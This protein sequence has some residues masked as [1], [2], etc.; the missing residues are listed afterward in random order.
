MTEMHLFHTTVYSF[1]NIMKVIQRII[2][3]EAAADLSILRGKHTE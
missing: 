2:D 1:V 3:L